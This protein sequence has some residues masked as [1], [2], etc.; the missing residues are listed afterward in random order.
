MHLSVFIPVLVNLSGS[1]FNELKSLS[2]G[3]RSV[4]RSRLSHS[5]SIILSVK[6]KESSTFPV[7]EAVRSVYVASSN[8]SRLAAKILLVVPF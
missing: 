8:V 7:S 4:T 2:F 1:S 5:L 3:I 6:I